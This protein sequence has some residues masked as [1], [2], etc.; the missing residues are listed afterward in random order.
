M[1]INH[2]DYV[3]DWTWEYP[4]SKYQPPKPSYR[5]RL[6][7]TILLTIALLAFA[8]WLNDVTTPPQCKPAAHK[9]MSQDCINLLYPN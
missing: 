2:P 1:D 4:A 5:V 8:Y 3:P 6:I 7:L 9:V